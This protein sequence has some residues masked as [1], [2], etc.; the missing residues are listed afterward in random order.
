MS[1]KYHPASHHAIITNDLY[2]AAFLHSAGCTLDH[3][4]TNGRKRVSFVFVGARVRQL[5]HA[6]RSGP[7]QLDMGRF[8]G[9]LYQLRRLM[10]GAIPE[11]RS[12]SHAGKA[13]FQAQ[14]HP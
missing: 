5:R 3:V 4:E 9:S 1:E 12:E 11:E 8:K 7:V 10:D 2:M 6:Y 14:S 13:R